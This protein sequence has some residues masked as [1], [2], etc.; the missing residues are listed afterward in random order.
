VQVRPPAAGALDDLAAQMDRVLVDAPCTGSGVWRRRPDAK[1]RVT[2]EALA[3]RTAEQDA[4]LADAA[5]YVKPGGVLAYA[6]CSLLAPENHG[7]VAAF[8]AAHADFSAVPM[9][10]AW[11]RALPDVAPPEG[12]IEGTSLLLTPLRSATDGFFLTLLRRGG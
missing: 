9:Q 5:S 7:R 1:W 3:K 4:V 6:T 8:L 12:A 10:E 11:A 2:P